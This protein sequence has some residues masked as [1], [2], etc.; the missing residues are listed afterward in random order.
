MNKTSVVALDNADDVVAFLDYLKNTTEKES[1]ILTNI[2]LPSENDDDNILVIGD[3][4]STVYSIV[5]ADHEF[6]AAYSLS[7][8]IEPWFYKSISNIKDMIDKY[9]FCSPDIA[10]KAIKDIIRIIVCEKHGCNKII[11]G[12][13]NK[14]TLAENLFVLNS[15]KEYFKDFD[16]DFVHPIFDKSDEYVETKLAEYCAEIGFESSCTFREDLMK[17]NWKYSSEMNNDIKSYIDGFLTDLL[18]EVYSSKIDIGGLD[19]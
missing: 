19:E 4:I 5:N 6:E 18:K 10:A 13:R 2:K 7:D 1:F 14:D 3:T 12:T 15:L 11:S 9:N 16:V 17:D 8:I